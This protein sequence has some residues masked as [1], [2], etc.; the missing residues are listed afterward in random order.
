LGKKPAPQKDTA[1]RRL[2]KIKASPPFR[3]RALEIPQEFRPAEANRALTLG[4]FALDDIVIRRAFEE[5]SSEKGGQ[6][7]PANPWHW[8]VVLYYL[9]HAF[10]GEAKP[11]K[12]KWNKG[13][14]AILNNRIDGIARAEGE[15]PDLEMGR[16]LIE[17]YPTEYMYMTV[18]SLAL[19]IREARKLR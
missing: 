18:K 6:L 12:T 1:E 7:D 13:R 10:F 3:A 4:F 8:R 11:K 2:A 15:K 16:R 19:R 9:A 14:L 17:L 5:L